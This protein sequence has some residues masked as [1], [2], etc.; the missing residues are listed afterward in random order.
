M[1]IREFRQS[2]ISGI[3]RLIGNELG[4]DVSVSELDF[5]IGQMMKEKHYHILIA[6]HDSRIAGFCG[7]QTSLAFEVPGRIMRII[8]LAVDAEYQREGL[9]ARLLREAEE[10]GRKNRISLIL[11][12]SGLQRTGAHQ[13]YEKQGFF[14]KGYSFCKRIMKKRCCCCGK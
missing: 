5:R 4:Y 3:C 1:E 13:F 11:V 6:E 12:N 9:G 8:A 10:Y 14:K 7:L 2:D